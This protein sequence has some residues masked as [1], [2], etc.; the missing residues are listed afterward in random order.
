MKFEFLNGYPIMTGSGSLF[1][2]CPQYYY[3]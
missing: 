1:F 2:C 3:Y